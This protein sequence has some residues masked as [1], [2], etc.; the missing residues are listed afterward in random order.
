MLTPPLAVDGQVKL[1]GHVPTVQN[2]KPLIG[3]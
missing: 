2:L 3:P 1:S